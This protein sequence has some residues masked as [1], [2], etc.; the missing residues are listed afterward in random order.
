MRSI[1]RDRPAGRCDRTT[2]RTA[3]RSHYP[4]TRR[5]WSNDGAAGRSVARGYLW[6]FVC[7]RQLSGRSRVSP[8]CRWP[9]SARRRAEA[10]PSA[11]GCG[12]R[13]RSVVDAELCA[14]G[15]ERLRVADASIMPTIPRG[16]YPRASIMIA[17]FPSK[18]WCRRTR[19]GRSVRRS[20]PAARRRRMHLVC[21]GSLWAANRSP[22]HV[23][24][25]YRFIDLS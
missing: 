10:C 2:A 3:S 7:S 14:R 8:R 19:T 23:R 22:R 24:T 20:C 16:H 13:P 4:G 12:W 25:L 21:R 5:R 6:L 1:T 18:C 17:E 9:R 11:R 15:V